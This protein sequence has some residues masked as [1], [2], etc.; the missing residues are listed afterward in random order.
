MEKHHEGSPDGAHDGSKVSGNKKQGVRN[1]SQANP[2]YGDTMGVNGKRDVVDFDDFYSHKP[3]ITI[4]KKC[5][6]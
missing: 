1:A 2:T 3:H 6:E 5:R 4:P